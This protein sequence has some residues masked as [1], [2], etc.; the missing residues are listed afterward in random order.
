ML[1]SIGRKECYMVAHKLAGEVNLITKEPEYLLRNIDD[2][3]LKLK[4]KEEIL[5]M[6]YS[7]LHLE[8]RK[9]IQIC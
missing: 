8:N 4:T 1:L 2:Y 6:F 9:V 3:V 5:W 7:R